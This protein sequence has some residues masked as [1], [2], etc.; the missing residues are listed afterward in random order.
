MNIE[1]NTDFIK[2]LKNALEHYKTITRH[3][4]IVRQECFAVGLYWQGLTHDL[5][6]Y[7]PTEFGMGIKYYQGWRSPN[8]AEREDKGY[9]DAWLHH[10]GRNRHHFEYWLDYLGDSGK[11]DKAKIVPCRMPVNYVVEM[12][13]DRLAASKVYKGKDYTDASAWEYYKNGDISEF[14]HPRTKKLLELLL[15]MNAKRGE[16]YTFEFIRNKLLI[17][18]KRGGCI[19]VLNEDCCCI[20]EED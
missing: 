15:K 18:K 14:L 3:R 17:K 13:M 6:K 19:P 10:K 8:V 20:S 11:G 4:R 12:F 5:S 1:I 7:S 9:S 2:R 16:A